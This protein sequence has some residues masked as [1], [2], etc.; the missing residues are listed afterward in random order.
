MKQIPEHA[1]SQPSVTAKTWAQTQ[2]KAILAVDN[3]RP[4]SRGLEL[5][6]AVMDGRMTHDDAVKA[7][8]E[9]AKIYAQRA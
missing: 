8:L 6:Q 5:S 2:S 4:S 1:V 7:I 9:R 3:I